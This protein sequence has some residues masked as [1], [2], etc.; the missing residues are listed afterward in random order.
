MPTPPRLAETLLRWFVPAPDAEA[1]GGDLEELM[2]SARYPR[3]W[4]TRQ[5]LSILTART[6]YAL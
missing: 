6:L 3:W 4:Y 5:V 1:L 2:P